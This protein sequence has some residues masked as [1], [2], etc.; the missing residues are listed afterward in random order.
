MNKIANVVKCS[1]CHELLE[2]PVLLP[3]SCN[4]CNKHVINQNKDLIR[5]E[6]CGV[7]HQIPTNSFHA[8]NALQM[9]I[10]AEI[11]KLDFGSGHKSAKKS[12]ES[13]EE[14]FN[15]LKLLLRDPGLYTH[16]KI[17]ELKNIVQLKGQ[18]LKLRIDEEMKKLMDR[19][20][21]YERESRRYLSTNEFKEESKKLEDELKTTQSNLDSWLECLNK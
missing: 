1:L 2:S 15:E 3:C 13:V 7:E 11:A 4:I 18:E 6:K 10:K 5:C 19:F 12:C 17:S 21:E 16:E 20:D 9:L 8:N 14:T